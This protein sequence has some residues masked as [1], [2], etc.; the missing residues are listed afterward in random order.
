VP[1]KRVFK[2]KRDIDDQEPKH[3]FPG[4]KS[5]KAMIFCTSQGAPRKINDRNTPNNKGNDRIH[6][7]AIKK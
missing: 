6:G 4:K 5:K 3:E 2:P 7:E 1:R